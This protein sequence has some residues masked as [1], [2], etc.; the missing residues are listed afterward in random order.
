MRYGNAGSSKL[1]ILLVGARGFE[2]PTS[3]PNHRCGKKLSFCHFE[4][5][6][7]HE[8]VRVLQ[9][10]H[11]RYQRLSALCCG[12]CPQIG[13]TKSGVFPVQDGHLKIIRV[14]IKIIFTAIIVAT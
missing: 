5:S 14:D 8:F 1:L 6:S 13:H 3:V 11:M 9:F 12:F 10:F 4:S 7:H 2:P